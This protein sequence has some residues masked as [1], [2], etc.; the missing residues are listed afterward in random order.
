MTVSS[1]KKERSR[2][3]AL[4][5][6]IPAVVIVLAVLVVLA[7]WIRP[8]PGV[9]SWLTTYPGA[10]HLPAGAPVGLPAWVGWQHFLNA[11]FV[12]LLIRSGLLIRTAKRPAA[13]W[14]RNNSGPIRTRNAPTRISINHWLHFTIDWLWIANGVVFLVLIFCTG[15]WVRIVPTTWDIFPNALSAALQYISLHWPHDDGWSNYN[16]LQLLTYFVTT[17]VAA[18]LAFVT[19]IRMSPLWPRNATRLNKAYPVE[20]ARAVHFPTMVY[21]AAFIVV[22][23]TLVLSTGALKNL[24]HVYASNDS[25]SWWGFTFFAISLIVLILG[26]VAVRPI[27]IQPIAQL[28]GKLTSR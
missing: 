6:A 27:V 20:L 13:F 24:N 21:F 2:W 10:S 12:L 18:P 23:V 22:H 9:Q 8:L 15:Q 4:A 3:R 17:F 11:F 7:M 19:G 5:W 14:T 25:Q 28:T 26:W 1:A 16:A